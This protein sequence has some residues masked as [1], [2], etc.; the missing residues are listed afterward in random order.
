MADG[1]RANAAVVGGAPLSSKFSSQHIYTSS[2]KY[3]YCTFFDKSTIIGRFEGVVRVGLP[4]HA[5]SG[6]TRAKI[7]HVRRDVVLWESRLG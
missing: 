7:P 6:E 1:G 3:R 5:H 2:N 4:V